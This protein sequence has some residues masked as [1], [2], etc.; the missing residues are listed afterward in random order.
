MKKIAL[1]TGCSSGIGLH[2]AQAL[3]ARGGWRVFASARRQEDV[4]RLRKEG[5]TDALR[6]DVDNSEDIKKTMNDMAEKTD[7]R[8]DVL[9]NNAGFGQPG[10]VEDV[11]IEALQAQFRT[12]V[13]GAHELAAE[14]VKLMRKTGGGRIIQNSSVLGFVCLKYRGA[15]NASKYAL[16]ALS[17]TM[18]MEL[19][20][21]GIHVILLQ[22]G[23]IISDFRRNA[24]EA[25]ERNIN[26]NDSAHKETYKRMKVAWE[27]GEQMKFTLPPDA[28]SEAFL[29]AV[30]SSSPKS[31]YRITTPTVM[32][33]YL[34][35]MLPI[36]WMDAI[37]SRN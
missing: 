28:V 9:F 25:F 13:F 27:G 18:R 17:D 30:E 22:P 5:F 36:K 20:G 7:G 6:L 21:T 8:L 2:C 11:G 35:R 15:Y 4:E 32:L 19:A 31:H 14:A 33:W 23:P 16:E 3:S 34:K 29:H 37:L 26:E 12:N 10:A 24:A 1:I